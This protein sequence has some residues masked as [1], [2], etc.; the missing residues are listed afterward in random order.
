M[1][2]HTLDL[3]FLGEKRA[4][5]AFLI[6]KKG[7][8]LVL[9]ETGPHSTFPVLEQKLSEKG[10]KTSDIGHVFVTHIHLDHAGSA[11]VFAQNGAKIYVHPAGAKHLSDPSRLMASAKMI[12]GDDMDRLWGRMENIAPEQLVFPQNGE[13]IRLGNLDITAWHTP[14]HAVH[15]ITWQVGQNLFTGDVAGVK[16]GRGPVVP[17][18]PPPDIQVEHWRASIDLMRNLAVKTLFLT[19]FGKISDKNSHL[20]A[21]EKRLVEY[22]DWM[23]TYFENEKPQAEIVPLF[24]AFSKKELAQ[25]GVGRAGLR[26]YAAANPPDMS[27]AGLMRYWAKTAKEQHPVH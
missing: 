2:I 13:K 4:I 15:H 25:N 10:L 22:A 6:E 20:D 23:K 9:V 24:T 19:H 21:L 14:G 26:K 5:A 27:V 8:P 18:C 3:E 7:S 17:P 12:Y 16:I 11:W 1:K